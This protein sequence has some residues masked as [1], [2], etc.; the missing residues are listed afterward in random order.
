[1]K[2]AHDQKLLRSRLA[3]SGK[4]P[5]R[6]SAKN[7]RCSSTVSM[8]AAFGRRGS[9][10]IP[11]CRDTSGQKRVFDH[12][13]IWKRQAAFRRR[14]FTNWFWISGRGEPIGGGAMKSVGKLAFV[15]VREAGHLSTMNQPRAIAWVIRCWV[16][17]KRDCIFSHFEE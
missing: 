7:C 11:R 15:S 17:R 1:M 16:A 2:R 8:R 14:G 13:I 5:A 12:L 6:L 9:V 10:L 4:A 3:W